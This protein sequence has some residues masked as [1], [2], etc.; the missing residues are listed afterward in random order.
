MNLRHA[1]ALSLVCC[2]YLFA[3]AANSNTPPQLVGGA[4]YLVT[5]PINDPRY[6][7]YIWG[8]YYKSLANCE[9]DRDAFTDFAAHGGRLSESN[10]CAG[11]SSSCP[12]ESKF[13]KG[14]RREMENATDQQAKGSLKRA[15]CISSNDVIL[16]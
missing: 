8:N 4:Y 1:A 10:P 5:P 13:D 11:R 6:H 15:R 3:C 9:M 12:W 2:L 16:P 14:P 7:W